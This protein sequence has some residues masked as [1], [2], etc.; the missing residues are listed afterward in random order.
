M[1]MNHALLQYFFKQQDL[2][3]CQTQWLQEFVETA[4]L[5]LYKP[6][7]QATIPNALSHSP[8]IH[9]CID[10]SAVSQPSCLG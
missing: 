10:K 4:I 9:D 8:I 6:G 5:M 3:K 1:L 2:N 7:K